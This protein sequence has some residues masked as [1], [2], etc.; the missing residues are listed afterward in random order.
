[1]VKKGGNKIRGGF[2]DFFGSPKLEPKRLIGHLKTCLESIK[3]DMKEEEDK[4]PI[5]Q[6]ITK[7]DDP[8]LELT[9]AVKQFY[10]AVTKSIKKY[11]IVDGEV[12]VVVPATTAPATTAPGD[13]TVLANAPPSTVTSGGKR[14]K[15]LKKGK[16]KCKKTMGRR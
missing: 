5:D 8:S 15:S 1:M 2:F 14:R 12:S 9:E 13:G 16:R 4:K 10:D 7:L 11:N 3:K 6:V